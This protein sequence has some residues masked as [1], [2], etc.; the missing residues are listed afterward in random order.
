MRHWCNAPTSTDLDAIL[1]TITQQQKAHAALQARLNFV[2]A[3]VGN[4]VRMIPVDELDPEKCTQVRLLAR[5]PA[6]QAL[7]ADQAITKGAWISHL[8][9]AEPIWV[10]APFDN[11]FA[12]L[13]GA[14][15]L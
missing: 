7:A 15:T 13:T 2:K 8:V 12:K 4:S 14:R 3:S 10:L 11:A 1:Q 6:K 9:P 5:D